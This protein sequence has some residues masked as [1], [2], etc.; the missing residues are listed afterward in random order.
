MKDNNTS[1]QNEPGENT[2]RS[3]GLD[4]MVILSLLL[5]NWYYFVIA[6]I[7]AFLG[8]R[9]YINHTMPVFRVE[10]TLLIHEDNNQTFNSEDLLQ[11]FG[12]PGSMSN[13]ENQIRI[14]TSRAVTE[15]ALN[16]LPFETE[17]YFKTFR[18]S[19]P[20][21][22][23]TPLRISSDDEEIPIPRDTEFSLTYL[24]NNRY[25]IECEAD[26][27]PLIRE[28]DF[29]E[30]IEINGGSLRIDLRDENYMERNRERKL[31]F[32]I[33]SH[34]NLVHF[35]NNRINVESLTRG[36]SLLSISMVGTN[37]K[38]DADFLNKLT[39]VFQSMSLDRKNTEAIRRI[40]FIDDQ[41]V[42]ISDS[43][44]LTENKLQQFRSRNR[45]MDVSAQG[46]AIIAQLTLLENDKARL[47]LEANYYDYLA[48]YL[49]KEETS[50]VP[51]VPITMGITD[52]G[53]TRLVTDLADLQSQFSGSA[54]GEMNPIQNRLAQRVRNT[55]EALN[56]TLNGLK[57]ANSLARH[58]NEQ[59]INKVNS[60]AAALP[61]TERQLLGIERKFRLNDEL[62]TFLLSTRAT[63]QM[64][65][66][67]NMADSEVIDPADSRFSMLVSPNIMMVRFI[68]VLAGFGIPFLIIFLNFLFD[69]KIKAEDIGKYTSLPVVGNIPF[70]SEKTNTVVFDNPN[71]SYTEAYRIL[72]SKMQF[73]TKDIH[74]P[75]ILVTS[76]MPE[77]GKT[78]MAINLAS[79][80]SLLG[81]KTVLVGFD[82]RKP[83]IFADFNISNEK[84]VSTYLIGQDKID[85]IIHE[86]AYKNL[87]VI[88]AGPIPPNPS[89]LT[90]LEK[91]DELLAYLKDHFDYIIIDSS[92]IGII[93]DTFHLARKADASLLVV[94][95][96]KTLKTM[97]EHTLTELGS[98][99]I[100]SLGIVV[101]GV[102]SDNNQYSYGEK[103]GYTS[104]KRRSR[105]KS[106]KK[107][108]KRQTTKS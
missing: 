55:K 43:L 38:R 53:L 16:E 107:K 81:K 27:F 80:Y 29:G 98:N 65:K 73:F 11:G 22:P 44:L 77:D 74:S 85:D 17:F 30:N 45:V 103:F 94:R 91:T 84:G 12:L 24:G 48:E 87:S 31:Y 88:S 40:Q 42:G 34:I 1:R 95:T 36:G 18:N 58:E 37:R 68:A 62:Y 60:Q 54:V 8:A 86:T 25:R 92:P 10:T 13:M 46:E 83:K 28:A 69:K 32:E 63:Q 49:A 106:P 93:S 101:N 99:E 59:Q 4:P 35:F 6:L 67:S 26:Y 100:S 97:L 82:L 89:E 41:L 9:L 108:A 51:I 70:S 102:H 76:S 61:A 15:R 20:I 52:P 96:R 105:R 72:R 56:E 90:A 7:I 78:Y 47:D 33:H 3:I 50:E 79:A 21:Y 64:Q 39:E 75:V 57:R 104:D 23:E 66:A 14:L 71:S 2:P 5:K 19:L